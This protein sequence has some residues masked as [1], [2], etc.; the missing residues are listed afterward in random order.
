M[1]DAAYMKLALE[2]A[3]KAGGMTSPNPQVGAVVV[4]DGRVV[5]TGYHRRAGEPHAE[6]FAL[7]E[8]GPEAKGATLYVNLEPCSHV[9]RTP[10]C[11]EAVIAAGINRVVAAMEDPNPGVAGRGFARLEGAGIQVDKGLMEAEARKVNEVF[12]KFITQNLPFV[13]LKTAATLDGKIATRT[14]AS[15]WITGEESR[16]FVHR[17]RSRH[18]GV[19][20][21][22]GTVLKD[23]PRLNVRLPEGGRDPFRVLVDSRGRVPLEAKILVPP[24]KTLI[25]VTR[26]ACGEKIPLLEER[27]VEVLVLPEKAGRVDLEA[28]LAELGRRGVTSLLVEG[29]GTLNY[30]LLAAGLVDKAYMFLAPLIF[31]GRDAPTSVDGEGI[32]DLAGAW[33]LEG[34]EYREIGDD[35]LLTGY[36]KGGFTNVHGPD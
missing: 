19:L 23:D 24:E 2:L 26:R 4:R 16:A 11:A 8:A 29:G 20:T 21:G 1:S 32:D 10:P 12:C 30:S 22:V 15:R 17:L 33:R 25:A 7:E 3:E 34:V 31:G 28:L 9:G 13:A 5:G 6:V 36:V 14:G 18:D 35:I 27:G